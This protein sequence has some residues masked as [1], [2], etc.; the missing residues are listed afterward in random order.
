MELTTRLPQ[1][2]IKKLM[3][4][5]I[6]LK[7]SRTPSQIANRHAICAQLSAL[8]LVG[9]A[10]NDWDPH[11]TLLICSH[12]EF[13][14]EGTRAGHKSVC[15]AKAFLVLGSSTKA[16]DESTCKC[17]HF[18]Q[19]R[20]HSLDHIIGQLSFVIDIIWLVN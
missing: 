19:M 7:I 16:S 14:K 13:W 20:C 17:T 5:Y 12:S 10:N 8:V 9:P 15:L 2:G 3:Q 18:I 6:I 11:I 4:I 1:E